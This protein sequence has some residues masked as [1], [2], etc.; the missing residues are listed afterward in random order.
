MFER[1]LLVLDDLG[2]PKI[3][4]PHLRVIARKAESHVVLLKTVPFLETLVEMPSELSPRLEGDDRAA[5]VYVAGLVEKLKGEGFDV[6]GFAHIGRSGL[7]IAA[8][9]DRVEASLVIIPSTRAWSRVATLLHATSVPVYVIPPHKVAFRGQ[10]LVPIDRTEH[11]LDVLSAASAL[12][13]ACRSGM[14]LL[15]TWGPDPDAALLE[16]CE[17]LRGQGIP[18]EVVVRP[19]EPATEIARACGEFQAGQLAMHS[20]GKAGGVIDWLLHRLP[21][22]LLVIRQAVAVPPTEAAAFG[23]PL[24]IHRETPLGVALWTRRVPANPLLGSGDIGS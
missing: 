9:A 7:S 2:D 20:D 15:Q 11:P 14:L 22:P 16:A 21:V 1:I 13:R 10:T 3:V 17:L 24:E 8:A 12:A 18:A 19:G 5:V 6:E 23:A 4:L